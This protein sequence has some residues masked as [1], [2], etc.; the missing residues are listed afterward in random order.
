MFINHVNCQYLSSN[1]ESRSFISFHQIFDHRRLAADFK[2]MVDLT[3]LEYSSNRVNSPLS[4]C[5]FIFNS[6]SSLRRDVHWFKWINLLVLSMILTNQLT[7]NSIW[8]HQSK[9]KMKICQQWTEYRYS[10]FILLKRKL[11]CWEDRYREKKYQQQQQI[12]M[13]RISRQRNWNK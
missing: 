5:V 4:L 11:L 8:L 12:H 9:I 1:I 3:I 13:K 6:I 10:I 7:E 2:Q